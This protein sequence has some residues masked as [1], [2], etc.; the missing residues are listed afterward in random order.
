MDCVNYVTEKGEN[1]MNSYF[2]GQS[3]FQKMKDDIIL[4]RIEK[5][6]K[7]EA[8]LM[9]L[10]ERIDNCLIRIRK[11]NHDIEIRGGKR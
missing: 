9:N 10:A 8:E 4:K 3:E 5:E 2:E 7:R 6:P 11:N 1:K